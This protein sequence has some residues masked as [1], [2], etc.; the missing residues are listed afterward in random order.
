M[1]IAS[2]RVRQ[3]RIVSQR[4]LILPSSSGPGGNRKIGG[5]SRTILT[6]G[7][8]TAHPSGTFRT[9]QTVII[10]LDTHLACVCAPIKPKRIGSNRRQN[11]IA[12]RGIALLDID[13]ITIRPQD[14][15][16]HIHRALVVVHKPDSCILMPHE[17]RMAHHNI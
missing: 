15:G 2:A 9:I 5:G 1:E 16:A 13:S 11:G 3:M 8:Q 6:A 14:T 12:H 7:L 17:Y 4:V 10:T